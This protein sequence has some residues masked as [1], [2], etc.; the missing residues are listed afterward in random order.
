M[1][2]VVYDI[3]RRNQKQP[4]G[5]RIPAT[6]TDHDIDDVLYSFGFEWFGKT[7][8]TQRLIHIS[9][10]CI[11]DYGDAKDVMQSAHAELALWDRDEASWVP[12]FPGDWVVEPQ[13]E[14]GDGFIRLS[15]NEFQDGWCV[16]K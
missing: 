14:D 4:R 7:V 1:T 3:S 5:V 9:D 12:V 15:D 6:L 16:G 2:A 13:D 8:G 10:D 11:D